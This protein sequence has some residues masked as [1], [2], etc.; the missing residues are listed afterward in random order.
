[1][2]SVDATGKILIADRNRHVREFLRRELM[3]EGYQVEVARDGHEVRE[4]I[5]GQNPPILL[6]LDLELPYLTELKVL[7]M[8]QE[9]L[10]SLPV[11][12]HSFPPESEEHLPGAAVFLEKR[13][14]TH[15][16]KEVV[17]ELLGKN[18]LPRPEA[19]LE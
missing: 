10:P 4:A 11:V 17:A 12:I 6:I 15:L 14:D 3:T 16:L 13:E 18:N 5:N 7:E 2:K 1:V 19:S 8:L 9:R